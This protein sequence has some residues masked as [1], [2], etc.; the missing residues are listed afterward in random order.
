MKEKK[1][2]NGMEWNGMEWNGMEWKRKKE[3]GMEWKGEGKIIYKSFWKLN[4]NL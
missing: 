1:K 2:E 4:N 3:T